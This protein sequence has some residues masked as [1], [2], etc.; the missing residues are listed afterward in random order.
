MTDLRT[1]LDEISEM[2]GRAPLPDPGIIQGFGPNDPPPP[3]LPDFPIRPPV[4]LSAVPEAPEEFFDDE[5]DS[6]LIPRAPEVEART[7][8]VRVPDLAVLGNDNAGT[9]A[10]Y[11][12]RQVELTSQESASVRRVVLKA[13][14]RR[15]KSELAEV[16]ALMPKRRTFGK[17]VPKDIIGTKDDPRLVQSI[18]IHDI[19]IDQQIERVPPKRRGR[20]PK[21]RLDGSV[22]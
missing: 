4:D 18:D 15:V 1:R 17:R 16:E 22:K 13:L 5:D 6:P 8:T 12:G 14:A 9:I 20:P 10:T 3:P 2:Q 21:Q 19:P 7:E 11:L